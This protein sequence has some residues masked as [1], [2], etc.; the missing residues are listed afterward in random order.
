MNEM[1]KIKYGKFSAVLGHGALTK[2]CRCAVDGLYFSGENACCCPCRSVHCVGEQE[3][4][5]SGNCLCKVSPKGAGNQSLKCSLKWSTTSWKR[6]G[7]GSWILF[8]FVG[9]FFK[10]LFTVMLHTEVFCVWMY[11]MYL[12]F[13][14]Y[15]GRVWGCVLGI[16]FRDVAHSCITVPI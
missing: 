1:V 4:F 13:F 8:G 7:G 11:G 15:L 12:L 6:G 2:C 3:V 9:F 16:L 10:A 5:G 14:T